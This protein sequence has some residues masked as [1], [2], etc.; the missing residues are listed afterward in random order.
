MKKQYKSK[1]IK[2]FSFFLTLIMLFTSLPFYAEGIGETPTVRIESFMR[3]D[4]TNG[5]ANKL[6]FTGT[7]NLRSSELLVAKM[8]NYDGDENNLVYKWTN[9]LNTYLYVY[10]TH[11]MYIAQYNKNRGNKTEQEIY[12]KTNGINDLGNM[13]SNAHNKT[14][15]GVGYNYAAVFGAYAYQNQN[16]TA[17]TAL[18]GSIKVEVFEQSNLTTPIATCEIAGL[19]GGQAFQA[20][21]LQDDIDHVVLGIF[22]GDT[23]NVKDLLGESAILHINCEHCTVTTASVVSGYNQR[24]FDER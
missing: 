23:R 12:N 14:Y 11:N 6:K 7:S 2:T 15:Q 4:V 16:N 20:F 1:C 8:Y 10:S 19:K 9:G 24:E 17:S 18:S 21:N 22:E 13:G 3:G 5:A